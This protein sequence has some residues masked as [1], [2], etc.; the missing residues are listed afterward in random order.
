MAELP[1]K[2]FALRW[3]SPYLADDKSTLVHLMAWCPQA[4]SH[5]MSKCRTWLK[6]PYG[7]TRSQWVKRLLDKRIMPVTVL[8][9]QGAAYNYYYLLIQAL[10][11][12]VLRSNWLH[13]DICRGVGKRVFT[14][15]NKTFSINVNINTCVSS[16]FLWHL[17]KVKTYSIPGIILG[18]GSAN[19]SRRPYLIGRAHI[20]NDHCIWYVQWS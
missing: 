4:A 12:T 2:K 18:M 1:L 16:L 13:R 7:V 19:E 14:V 20:Q 3:M 17:R 5:Y 9:V 11:A 6:S 10:R 15:E 8:M